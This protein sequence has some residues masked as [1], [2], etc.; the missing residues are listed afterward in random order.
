MSALPLDPATALGCLKCR[1][2]P[3]RLQRSDFATCPTTRS[4]PTKANCIRNRTS[5][6]AIPTSAITQARGSRRRQIARRRRPR[7]NHSACQNRNRRRIRLPHGTKPIARQ[8]IVPR[9]GADLCLWAKAFLR[10]AKPLGTG[11]TPAPLRGADYY[12]EALSKVRLFAFD[13]DSIR[14]F[15]VDGVISHP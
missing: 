14:G 2:A 5:P 8:T 15:A 6:S 7:C 9:P 4:A 3:A 10:P 13:A 1:K 12:Q 11:K